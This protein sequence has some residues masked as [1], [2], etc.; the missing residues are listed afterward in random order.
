[1]TMLVVEIREQRERLRRTI[2][3]AR[4]IRAELQPLLNA[5]GA[6]VHFRPSSTG[7]AMVGL[8]PERPQRGKSKIRNL[9]SI[10]DGFQV[11]FDSHC[12]NVEQGRV[13]G[14][15]ALQSF[16][17][18]EAQ[19]N[20]RRLASLNRASAATDDPVEL[21][22]I[23]DEIS[24]PVE[25][26]KTVCDLLAL[27]RDGGRCTPVVIEL[28]DSRQLTR[29]VE[30]VEGYAALLD[31]HADLFAELFAALL[32][33]DITFGGPAEKWIVWPSS[34]TGS[35]CRTQE[36]QAHGIRVVA[37]GRNDASY[38]FTVGP[39]TATAA[40][41]TRTAS[42]PDTLGRV[43]GCLLGGAVGDA[44]GAPVEFLSLNEIRRSFGPPGIQ[45]F[46][47]AYGRVGAITDDTQMTLFTA[48]GLIRA[49]VRYSGKGI[50]HPPSIIH[51][52][53][54]RWLLTQ[55]ETSPA[56][57]TS[58]TW[59][60]GWLIH[61]KEL[62]ARRAPGM[63]CMSALKGSQR[64][65]EEA[66]NDSKGC[67]S[68]MR[69]APIGLFVR[70]DDE[71]SEGGPPLAFT[72][73]CESAKSTHG[74][75]SSTLASGFFSLIIAHLLRGKTLDEAIVSSRRWVE[76]EQGSHEVMAAIDGAVTLASSKG[77]SSPETVERLGSGWV[78]EEALAISLFCALRAESF[79]HGVRLAVNH[80]G[81]SDSTGSLTG[82]LL[83]TLWGVQSLP[84]RWLEQLEL[85]EVIEQLA[86]DLVGVTEGNSDSYG[87]RYPGW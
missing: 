11:M 9:K 21:V 17:I 50:C 66:R 72:M 20:G 29:L 81:D 26:G 69:I 80:S 45:E 57:P 12:R 25:G 61:R 63:T 58:D 34:G 39:S 40:T 49:Q 10:S 75:V 67:G 51:H 47:P 64:F 13:T 27:R 71:L 56:F 62:H 38:S 52:A 54:L 70:I 30:Q 6:N 42:A 37:Y 78:A 85:P 74:H 19:T 60:D 79:E 68:I 4:R 16:L 46:A 18:S 53:L 87:D 28:K 14:E 8:L 36:L 48:E 35:E 32:G 5:H 3:W 83:G 33:E 55:G 7:I 43:R 76:R 15:K 82:Q 44:L 1:L 84:P 73:A 77:P 86:R 24:L 22:F 59:P 23:T 31:V 2:K 41:G 65:G